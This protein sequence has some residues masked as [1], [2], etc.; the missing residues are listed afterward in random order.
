MKILKNKERDGN[1]YLYSF[2]LDQCCQS[3]SCL[4][5]YLILYTL[6]KSDDIPSDHIIIDHWG[7][8]HNGRVRDTY[9]RKLFERKFPSFEPFC[10]ETKR[11]DMGPWLIRLSDGTSISGE[12]SSVITVLAENDVINF[13]KLFIK[14]EDATYSLHEYPVPLVDYLREKENMTLRSSVQMLSHISSQPNIY[15]E[16]CRCLQS[17][18]YIPVENPVQIEGYTAERLITDMGLHPVGAYSTLVDLISDPTETLRL[19]KRG[20]IR[21]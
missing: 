4:P 18:E 13:A 16:F 2:D 10:K 7:D 15:E 12:A 1:Y 17:G 6:V 19:I 20:I 21:K 14:V 8:I 9:S 11:P 5:G 3:E